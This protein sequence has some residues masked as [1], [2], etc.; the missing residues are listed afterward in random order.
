MDSAEGCESLVTE[1]VAIV[2]SDFTAARLRRV[3]E[4]SVSTS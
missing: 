3:W 4:V 2:L 1:E